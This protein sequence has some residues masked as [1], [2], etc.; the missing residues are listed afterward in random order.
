MYKPDK[1]KK[2]NPLTTVDIP[3]DENGRAHITEQYLKDLCA[4]NGQYETAYL[5]DTLYLHFKG[6][7]KIECLEKYT[8]LKSIWLES[9]GL[10]RIQGLDNQKKLRMLMLNQNVITKIENVNHLTRLV[11]LNLANNAISKIEGLE[12]L[13]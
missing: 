10:T 12:G 3:R 13:N 11:K 1:D 8:H 4:L 9:N 5:N 2:Y 7:S 6:F